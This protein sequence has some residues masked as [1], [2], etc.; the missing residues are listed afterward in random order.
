MLR[1]IAF[2]P[3]G[4]NAKNA[5]LHQLLQ[6]YKWTSP[7]NIRDHS[8]L[9]PGQF[10]VDT[11]SPQYIA[12]ELDTVESILAQLPRVVP[13]SIEEHHLTTV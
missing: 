13:S 7:F 1:Y 4:L 9:L 10:T 6:Q 11:G 8:E 3:G 2:V 12:C 5:Q